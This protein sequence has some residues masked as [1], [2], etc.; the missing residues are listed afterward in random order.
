MSR[1]RYFVVVVVISKITGIGY[2]AGSNPGK[3]KLAGR[4]G[5]GASGY[6]DGVPIGWWE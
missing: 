3:S 6:C 4:A 2:N 1:E 5:G